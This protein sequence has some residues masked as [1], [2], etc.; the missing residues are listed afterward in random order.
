M[1]LC[2]SLVCGIQVCGVRFSKTIV[3]YR[4]GAQIVLISMYMSYFMFYCNTDLKAALKSDSTIKHQ[5][6]LRNRKSYGCVYYHAL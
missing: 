3:Q 5:R 1:N 4:G 2:I 6:L